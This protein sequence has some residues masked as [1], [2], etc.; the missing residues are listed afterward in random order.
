MI[1][2]VF[3]TTGRYNMAEL[4]LRT[5]FGESVDVPEAARYGDTGPSE[6]FLVREVDNEPAV[7]T[8]EDFEAGFTD[9]SG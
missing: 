5:V 6:I 2:I 3:N 7:I 4:Y 9:L 1:S 8:R